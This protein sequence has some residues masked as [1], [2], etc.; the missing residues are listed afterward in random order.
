MKS[1]RKASLY[2]VIVFLSLS[3]LLAV[4]SLLTG[5]FGEVQMK[6]ILTTLTISAASVCGMACL[7]FVEK[8]GAAALG[9]VGVM[10]AVI[11]ASMGIFAFWNSSS[12]STEYAKVTLTFVVASV[13]IAHMLLLHIP[14]LPAGWRWNQY[15]LVLFDLILAGQVVFAMWDETSSSGFYRLMGVITVF[16]VFF[17]LI[18]PI[19]SRL[20]GRARKHASL[21]LT[22]EGDDIYFDRE[23]QRYRV[24]KIQGPG[25]SLDG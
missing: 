9:G 2:A 25:G 13:A 17:T 4:V 14:N 6:I 3:A 23:G 16:V 10:C 7:A 19:G 15:A 11:A 22:P 5:E 20:T 12:V 21:T 8:R 18:I 24:T 1:L